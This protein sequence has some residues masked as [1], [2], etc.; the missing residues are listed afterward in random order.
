M[1]NKHLDK[2]P[3]AV[4][5]NMA[6]TIAE[7]KTAD[8]INEILNIAGHQTRFGVMG[9]KWRFLYFDVFKVLNF[10]TNGQYEIAKI[11]QLF[12]DP[13]RWIDHE[14][15]QKKAINALNKA[16]SYVNLQINENFKI[17]ITSRIAHGSPI[18]AEASSA[19]STM[20]VSPIFGANTFVQESD[21]CFILMPFKPAFD[22]LYKEHL[23]PSIES[24]GFRCLRA[25]DFFTPTPIFNDI[26]QHICKSKVIIADVTGRNPNVF[27]EMGVAHTVGRQVIIITQDMNDVP[28]DIAQIRY[29]LYSDNESGWNKLQENIIKAIKSTLNIK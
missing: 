17:V 27:Y 1:E 19:I 4:L 9:T 14:D 2:F 3:E 20:A 18:K 28:F 22:R 13:V 12:C 23:K 10:Q 5:E 8:E 29:F 24:C 26:W 15:N 21:L 16:L 6:K 11:I 25:D 7:Y